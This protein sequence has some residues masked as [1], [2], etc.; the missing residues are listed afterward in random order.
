MEKVRSSSEFN[1]KNSLPLVSS[2]GMMK[3]KYTHLF[4]DLDNTLW[5]FKTNSR[6]AMNTTF[7][8]F[9]LHDKNVAF[10]K[11]FAVYSENNNKLWEAY[12]KKEVVKKELI[13]QRFQL[14]FDVLNIT[15]IDAQEMNDFYLTE[16]PR[17]VHLVDGTLKVLDYL[18]N[19]GYRLFIITNGFRMVQHKKLQSSGLASYFEKIFISEEVKCPKPGKEIFQYAIK[20]SNARKNSSLMI[21]DD[22]DVDV[23]GALNFGIDA[24]HFN[25]KSNETSSNLLVNQPLEDKYVEINT[26]SRLLLI[27]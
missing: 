26:L 23:K 9:C 11:F 21:G 19:N 24:V 22:L 16:M 13:R 4:F 3:K 12:R 25:Y 1:K 18:K 5:D 6:H 15:G 2:S 14:T 27:L 17:Q 7:E 10:D 20:S 8:A